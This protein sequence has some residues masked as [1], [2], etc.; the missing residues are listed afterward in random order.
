MGLINFLKGQDKLSQINASEEDGFVDLKLTITEYWQDQNKNHIC[1]VSGLWKNE[2]VGFEIAFRPDMKTGIVDDEVDK[3]RFYREGINIYSI[4]EP[5]DKFV[6][7]LIE[8]YKL[9]CNYGKMNRKICTTTFV[10]GGNP[11]NIK[12]EY[13]KTKVFLD[14]TDEKGFYSELFINIDLK[15]KVLELREKDPEY[16]LNI[17]NML[18]K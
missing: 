13:I 9:S 8:L 3:S 16:R 11:D 1:K 4:G 12:T 2:V 6:K 17:I 10:L 15:N 5:S 14:D 18:T 7:A